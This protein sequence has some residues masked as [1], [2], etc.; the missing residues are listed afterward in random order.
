MTLACG[1]AVT[2][3]WMFLSPE[4]LKTTLPCKYKRTRTFCGFFRDFFF[5]QD[6]FYCFGVLMFLSVYFWS[7]RYCEVH[8]EILC[9]LNDHLN[10]VSNLT[11]WQKFVSDYFKFHHQDGNPQEKY[12]Q[13]NFKPVRFSWLDNLRVGER[14]DFR[15][16][17]RFKIS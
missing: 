10:Q 3:A 11:K 4:A 17:Y 12:F 16:R 7:R 1:Y 15:L 5:C 8:E 9:R 2:H 13:K 14:K 6:D